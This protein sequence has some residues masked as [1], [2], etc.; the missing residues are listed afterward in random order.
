MEVTEF[1]EHYSSSDIFEFL[2]ST[3][4]SPKKSYDEHTMIVCMVNRETSVDEHNLRQKLREF[5]P[6]GTIYVLGRSHEGTPGE[7]I[8]FSPYPN[9]TK[10][11]KFNL[12][13]TV[14]KYSIPPRIKLG[15]GTARKISYLATH[16]EP[17]NTY[18]I[19]GLN[20]DLLRKKYRPDLHK[21]N[22]ENI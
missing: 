11:L 5:N 1:E 10:S 16:L 17:V 7:F 14:L 22:L 21:C 3:K 19:F 6:K 12:N 4:L 15:M 8:I 13:T 9:P 20:G 18:D 2:R